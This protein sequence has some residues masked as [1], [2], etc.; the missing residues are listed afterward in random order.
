LELLATVELVHS[1]TLELSGVLDKGNVCRR[2][3]VADE[4]VTAS[5]TS[6]AVVGQSGGSDI[7]DVFGDILSQEETGAVGLV[8]PVDEGVLA[9][10]VE[11]AIL[12]V[13][14][15]CA[16][17]VGGAAVGG[18]DVELERAD[19]LAVKLAGCEVVDLPDVVALLDNGAG[20]GAGL[21]GSGHGEASGG[22]EGSGD[23]L[24]L[25]FEDVGGW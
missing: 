7:L 6:A 1:E 19:G 25:H 11:L 5:T 17:E 12:D 21:E 22:E 15:G 9:A 18:L 2:D 24:E 10:L 14:G 23:D 20:L 3:T 13:A 16:V 8:S 4:V